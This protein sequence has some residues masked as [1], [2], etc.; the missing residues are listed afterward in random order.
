M[1]PS[2]HQCMQQA[3]GEGWALR[4]CKKHICR[5]LLLEEQKQQLLPG[6]PAFPVPCSRLRLPWG[7]SMAQPGRSSSLGAGSGRGPQGV[8]QD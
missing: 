6:P 5:S 2:C 8:C 1:A 3:G 4:S 7:S